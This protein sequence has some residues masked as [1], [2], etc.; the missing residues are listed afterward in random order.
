MSTKCSPVDENRMKSAFE[1]IRSDQGNIYR[2]SWLVVG[3]IDQN[4][5][6]IDVVASSHL[7]E[8]PYEELVDILK[9]DQ[10]MYVLIRL[11]STFDMSTTVKFV[12]IHWFVFDLSSKLI[13]SIK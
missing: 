9:N 13:N 2:K 5:Q 3:H 12:Y 11:T 7:S 8:S 4:P 1:D 6:L 10:V